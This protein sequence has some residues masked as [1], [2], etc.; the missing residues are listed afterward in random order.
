MILV[1]GGSGFVGGAIVRQLVA[2]GDLVRSLQRHAAPGL[3]ALGIQTV[4]GDLADTETVLQA[5]RGC[6]AVIH[7]AAKAGVWGS[8]RDYQLANVRG[9]RNVLNACKTLGIRKL[10]YTST[11]SVVHSGGDVEGID[12]ATP[13][14]THFSSPYA[15]SKADAELLVL[16]ANSPDLATVALRPHLVWGPNDPQ[17]TGR[18]LA[19]AKSGRLRLVGGGKKRIDST[20]IDNAALAHVLAL[21][22]VRPGAACAGRAYFIAQD[23]PM[24]QRDLINGILAAGGLPPCSQ[25]VSPRIAW[26]LGAL[27]EG[28]G[29]LR[30]QAHEPMMT[31]FLAEQ[32]A[33]AH[34]Y[35]LSAA[36][37]DLDYVPQLTV[38]Q[39]LVRLQ[40]WLTEQAST[41]RD[42]VR[43]GVGISTAT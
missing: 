6:D 38:A 42:A 14:A 43:A 34:W 23:E 1:T 22:R 18:I 16:Q 8:A 26:L 17:L 35:D 39:G 3:Q 20:Y 7:V 4:C 29:H 5:A 12:E 40:Q 9:T 28:F 32:L 11:P 2:R 33:T 41:D 15:Q 21:D 10:V 27:L 24:P 37:R 36:R 19:R 30:Q 25:S 31:R 13:I